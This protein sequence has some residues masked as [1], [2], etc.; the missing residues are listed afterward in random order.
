MPDQA[1]A[2]MALTVRLR[3]VPMVRTEMRVPMVRRGLAELVAKAAKVRP[4][5]R[6]VKTAWMAPVVP[7]PLTN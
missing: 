4:I 3:R 1:A 7:D 2:W 5:R 6:P